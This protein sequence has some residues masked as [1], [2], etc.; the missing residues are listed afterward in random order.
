VTDTGAAA[1]AAVPAAISQSTH[2]VAGISANQSAVSCAT[3]S[4]AQGPTA[5][6]PGIDALP[7]ALPQRLEDAQW[8]L[9]RAETSCN[10][11]WGEAWCD[12]ATADLDATEAVLDQLDLEANPKPAV[13]R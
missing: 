5:A 6:Q 3:L 12:R 13:S 9:L 2:R 8:H 7:T 1:D 11:F 4:Q 10:I